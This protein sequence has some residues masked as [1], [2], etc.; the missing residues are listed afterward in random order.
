MLGKAELEHILNDWNF[1]N[2]EVPESVP[3]AVLSKIPAPS[4]KLIHVIQGVRRSGKSTLMTQIIKRHQLDPKQCLFINF[5]D[6]RLSN[7]LNTGLLDELVLF[8]DQNFRAN[9][10]RY[11]F[12]D[13]I[14]E[15][16]NWEKWLHVK[17]ER[18]SQNFFFISGSNAALLS[19]ELSTALT[20]RHITTE[21]F[22][23]DFNEYKLLKPQGSLQD[24]IKDGGFPAVINYESPNILLQEYF[25]DI[26]E[27][28][29]RRRVGA[30]SSL[31]LSQL[32][33]AVFEATGSEISMRSLAQMLSTTTDTVSSYLE[34]CESAYMI[35]QCP[36][37][38]FSEKQ[39]AARNRKYYPI[40]LGL[41]NAVITK[42][43]QDLGKS[44]ETLV[45]HYLRK[46]YEKVFYWRNSG[47]V[48]FVIQDGNEI[49]PYQVSWDDK[50]DRHK[51][52]LDDFYI[53]FPQAKEAISINR[54]N[55]EELI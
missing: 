45:F 13:E 24:F 8:A 5:E 54:D 21:L 41:R 48:D 12:F 44:L 42:G 28:D 43:G 6:P 4:S 16:E 40:D 20:G 55:V 1:W 32:V 22:P 29:V 25:K 34:A 31:M 19:G 38:T 23:F 18:P 11:F 49:V 51:K 39:R 52:A 3:R 7:C 9:E 30:R 26:I 47:E 27:R 17:L 35:F 36:Y 15:V 14:Q 46:K 2:K 33:K 37:F 53:A 50:K 10:K